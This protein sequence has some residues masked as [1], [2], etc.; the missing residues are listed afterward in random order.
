MQRYSYQFPRDETE[1]YDFIRGWYPDFVRLCEEI[2]VLLGEDK[3]QFR[4]LQLKEKWGTARYYYAMHRHQD[5]YLD[6]Q[7]PEGAVTIVSN[8]VSDDPVKIEI[9]R[10]VRAAQDD[11]SSIC[12]VCGEMGELDRSEPYYVTLCAQHARTRDQVRHLFFL[13]L[14]AEP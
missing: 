12:M 11:T 10:L 5:H 7:S 8:S 6:L 9:R 13:E 3:R 2:D 4:W 1:W 14:D